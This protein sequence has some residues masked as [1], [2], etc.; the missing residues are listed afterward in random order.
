MELKLKQRD[1]ENFYDAIDI[2]KEREPDLD[3]AKMSGVKHA[4]LY[5]RIGVEMGLF[6]DHPKGTDI[7]D[8]HPAIVLEFGSAFMAAFS[9]ATT[10]PKKSG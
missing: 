5:A 6:P 8:I 3:V 2:V 10:I 9:E 1:I 7:D 4:G